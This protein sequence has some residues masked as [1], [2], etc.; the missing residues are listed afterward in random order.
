MANTLNRGDR[1]PF[2]WPLTITDK[3]GAPATVTE[4]EVAFL[5]SGSSPTP[6]AVFYVAPVTGGKARLTLA[7]AD[8]AGEGGIKLTSGQYVPWFRLNDGDDII[9]RPGPRITVA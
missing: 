7:H 9:T 3:D 4:V 6:D 1:E 5:R 8:T 2:T